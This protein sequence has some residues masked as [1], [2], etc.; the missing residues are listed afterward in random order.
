MPTQTL[1]REAHQQDFNLF[2]NATQLF[3]YC[4]YPKTGCGGVLANSADQVLQ[5]FADALPL[6]SHTD[7]E[8]PS[9]SKL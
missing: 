7:G 2:L 9:A 1:E 6:S 8:W 3:R 5:L 4:N